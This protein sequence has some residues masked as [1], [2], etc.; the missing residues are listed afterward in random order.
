[1]ASSEGD[2]KAGR[3][4]VGLWWSLA[5]GFVAWA[6]DLGLSYMF[7]HRSC[8]TGHRY[9]LHVINTLCLL[10]ALSGFGT[11]M[12]EFKRFPGT[13]SEEGGTPF[14]R[15]HFQG[16]LGMAFSLSFAVVIV[17]GSVPSWILSPCE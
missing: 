3:T 10:I 17:A 5:A 12:F 4:P 2:I 15:A 1:M 14:D 16:L 11:G 6:A 8:S 7:E 9:L 13:T